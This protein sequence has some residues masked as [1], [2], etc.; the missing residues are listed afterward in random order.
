MAKGYSKQQIEFMNAAGLL[1][2]TEAGCY[3][4]RRG[5][6]SMLLRIINNQY[7]VSV[8]AAKNGKRCW[9]RSRRHAT[10]SR[11][12]CNSQ[13]TGTYASPQV[14]WGSPTAMWW[15]AHLSCCLKGHL[16]LFPST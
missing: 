6:Y 16:P 11:T 5:E 8:S 2:D 7:V 14:I 3:F 1:L 10:I 4:G 9:R 13:D 15:E 12:S